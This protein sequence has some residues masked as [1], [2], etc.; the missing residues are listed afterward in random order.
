MRLTKLG[1]E[2]NASEQPFAVPAEGSEP[3]STHAVK[4][5]IARTHAISR[6][7]EDW[8]IPAQRLGDH[9]RAENPE[10][11]GRYRWIFCVSFSFATNIRKH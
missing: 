6:G 10:Q 4:N 1:K 7:I 3:S 5:E 9:L 11:F 2:D 8:N